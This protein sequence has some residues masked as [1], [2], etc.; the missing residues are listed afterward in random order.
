MAVSGYRQAGV[1]TI[2]NLSA[3]LCIVAVPFLLFAGCVRFLGYAD[4]L[5]DSDER[6]AVDLHINRDSADTN[7]DVASPDVA[8]PDSNPCSGGG[9]LLKSSKPEPQGEHTFQVE[10]ALTSCVFRFE[11][12]GAGGGWAN[13]TARGGHGGHNSFEFIPGQTGLLVMVVGGGG[14]GTANHRD[15]GS[16]GGASSVIFDPDAQPDRSDAYELSIA[17]GGGGEGGNADS[18]GS[19]NGGDGNGDGKGATVGGAP[20]SSSGAGV[21]S[22]WGDCCGGSCKAGVVCQGGPGGLGSGYTSGGVPGG[23]GKGGGKGGSAAFGAG[24]GGGYGGAAGSRYNGPGG[25]GGGKVFSVQP[26]A[27]LVNTTDTT[28]RLGGG[29]RGGTSKSP[30]GQDG[31]ITFSIGTK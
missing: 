7:P 20:G 11:V 14:T 13:H 12:N 19:E 5:T 17:G 27:L 18:M 3:R 4:S 25:G 15:G 28:K 1:S 23:F 24:G 29:G 26:P 22:V 8:S 2:G 9:S 10:Q 30:T 21:C 16:G 31:S 6:G